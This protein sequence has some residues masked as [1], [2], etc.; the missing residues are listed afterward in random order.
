MVLGFVCAANSCKLIHC[1]IP[2]LACPAAM[3]VKVG[4]GVGDGCGRESS[5]LSGQPGTRGAP[6]SSRRDALGR[7]TRDVSEAVRPHY[8]VRA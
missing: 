1:W 3:F 7:Y 4:L 8:R 2:A 6:Q 5:E